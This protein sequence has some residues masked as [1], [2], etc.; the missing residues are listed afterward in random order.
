MKRF[1]LVIIVLLG[2]WPGISSEAL[3]VEKYLLAVIMAN[4]QPRYQEIHS[5]FVEN[6]QSYC[7][8]DCRI[9]VQ[10][11]NADVMS[12]RNSVRKA[13]ALGADLIITYGP[14]ATLAAQS[15]ASSIPVVFVD[16]Y[17]PVRL[18]LISEKSHTGR[19]MTG[20]RGDA[21]VQALF[22]Y[23]TEATKAKKLAVLYDLSSPE[24]NLQKTVL[25]ESGKKKAV[26][27]VPLAVKDLKDHVSPLKDMPVD[28]DGLFLA[29]GEHVDSFLPQVLEFAAGRQI[30]VITQRAGTAE[31]G[32]F[33]V[34]ETSAVEQGEQLAVFAGKVLAG[35]NASEI[36]IYTPRQVEF[37]VNLK[38]A[39]Q[40][41][42]QV[43]FKTLSVASRVVR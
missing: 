26:D 7:G 39:K 12:L 3:S 32:A 24:G 42:I 10:T 36:A 37:I 22:N 18:N 25:M 13:V 29:S 38:V 14:A 9:Y 2:G 27:V 17:D 6:S 35:K 1:L 5:T 33:M 23:F 28:T 31:M 34:L 41:D 20:V 4:S 8:N 30:P 15:E 43:P 16:V 40:Y 19:N 11:P 21:P